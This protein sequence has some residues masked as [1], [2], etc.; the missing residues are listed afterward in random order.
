MDQSTKD[1]KWLYSAI[2]KDSIKKG[3]HLDLDKFPNGQ[4]SLAL[5]GKMGG[6]GDVLA[7]TF[8]GI[9]WTVFA[10]GAYLGIRQCINTTDN[11]LQA[12]AKAGRIIT[13]IGQLGTHIQDIQCKAKDLWTP[14]ERDLIKLYESSSKEIRDQVMFPRYTTYSQIKGKPEPHA[15]TKDSI[16]KPGDIIHTPSSTP[17]PMDQFAPDGVFQHHGTL[18]DGAGRVIIDAAYDPNQMPG[19]MFSVEN[20][21]TI[22]N[23]VNEFREVVYEDVGKPLNKAITSIGI[24][25]LAGALYIDENVKIGCKASDEIIENISRRAGAPINMDKFS[26]EV[27]HTTGIAIANTPPDVIQTA[28]TVAL[29]GIEVA[30]KGGDIFR[31]ANDV[32]NFMYNVGMAIPEEKIIEACVIF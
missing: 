15:F 26:E 23:S 21:A 27:L 5:K 17:T 31:K 32:A 28:A 25:S 8:Y 20:Q 29:T 13:A 22:L 2:I 10:T 7:W 16:L 24:N 1:A 6:T 3:S 14:E 18:V 12:A 19:T 30:K 4:Y 9:T 11:L